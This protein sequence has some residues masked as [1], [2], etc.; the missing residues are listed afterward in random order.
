M[1]IMQT[2]NDA[3][4]RVGKGGGSKIDPKIR[5]YRV[6]QGRWVGQKW[7]KNVGRH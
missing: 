1:E 3:H 4:I 6:G 7:P 5:C 2:N